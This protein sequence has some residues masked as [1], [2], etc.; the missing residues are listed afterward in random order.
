MPSNKGGV[1]WAAREVVGRARSVARLQVE[2]ALLEIKKKLARIGIGVGLGAGAALLALYLVGFL[3][4][5]AAA[6]LALVVPLWASLL[7]VAGV[8]LLLIALLVWL[9]MRSFKAG[10]PPIPEEA[11]EEAI[12]TS[13]TLRSSVG[14]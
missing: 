13:E 8:L 11:V 12:L 7:I 5:A 4:A 2:L 14:G 3:L 9:A 10:V 1:G 6:G